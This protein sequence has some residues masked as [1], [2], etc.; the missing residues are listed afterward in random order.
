MKI[1]LA[2]KLTVSR[3][4]ILIVTMIVF[5]YLCIASVEK[6][7]LNE[8]IA[9]A[10]IMSET[11][12]RSVNYH[13]IEDDRKRAY[14]MIEEISGQAG[15]ETIRFFNHSGLISFST[16]KNEEGTYL[17]SSAE[18]CN[19]CHFQS[20]VSMKDPLE[21]HTRTFT[22][23]KGN[24]VLGVTKNILNE[25]SCSNA[26]CHAHPEDT[27]VLGV[28]DIHISLEKMAAQVL[29]AR[30]SIIIFT[31]GMVITLALFL[32]LLIDRLI[33]RP[34]AELLDHT[35]TLARGDLSSRVERVRNDE[36][37]ELAEAFN[38]MTCNLEVAHNE[39]TEWGNTLEQKVEERTLEIKQMQ[40]ELLK[41]AK[42]ALLGELVAGIAHEINNPLT[43]ILTFS[44]MAANDPR[45]HPDLKQDLE[46]VIGETERC[47]R[48]VQSLLKA[49]HENVLE[50]RYDCLNRVLDHTLA[51]VSKRPCLGAVNIVRNY[52]KGLPACEVDSEQ[53]EQVFM[54]LIINAGQAMPD[55][56]TLRIAT[57]SQGGYVTIEISDTGVGISAEQVENIFDP[58]FTTKGRTKGTGLGLSI[59]S[60]IVES[61]G[62]T[63][64][65]HSQ[66][67]E[68]TTF[69]LR[70]PVSLEDE[71]GN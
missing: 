10:D 57:S 52:D 66:V 24:K 8:A 16:E 58:F 67:G 45:L 42:L 64:N 62:G 56:G 59:S 15:I 65:V 13:M 3:S 36:F 37:G 50:K 33:N 14:L 34:V 43:G 30:N 19:R 11:I 17:D 49:S 32:N 26:Q 28:L 20:P 25:A 29:S 44:S 38:A 18:G 48:I 41:S 68:G 70:L 4:L 55:G 21:L 60:G 46:M 69:V 61:H 1:N 9:D 7:Y 27:V 6:M 63:I 23:S 51:L 5:A 53:I 47:A 39:L 54:N 40:S 31:I 22:N 2:T 71:L 35:R 12:I